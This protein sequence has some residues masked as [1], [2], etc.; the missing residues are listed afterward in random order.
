[1]GVGTNRDRKVLDIVLHRKDLLLTA[2]FD[3]NRRFSHLDNEATMDLIERG[4]VVAI[5]DALD[6]EDPYFVQPGAPNSR[7]IKFE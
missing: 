1:M 2:I 6:F 5:N 7:V 3:Q 4:N